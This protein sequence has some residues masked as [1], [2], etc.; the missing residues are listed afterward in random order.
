MK[1][2]YYK[3]NFLLGL[4][5]VSATSIFAQG[6]IEMTRNG[7]PTNNGSGVSTL[8]MTVPFSN[9]AANNSTFSANSPALTLTISFKN[10]QFTGLN[11]GTGALSNAQTTGLVFGAAPALASD[12][13]V[14]G[15]NAFPRYNIIGQYGGNG[16]PTNAM[17]TSSST[18]AATAASAS[19]SG[20]GIKVQ[21]SNATTNGAFEVFTTAQALFGSANG[22]GSRVYF[23]DIVLKFSRPVK[24]PVI[25]VAGLG[26][27]Y[28]FLPIGLTGLANYKRIFFST[29]L[30]LVNTGLTST[31]MSGNQFISLSGNNILNSNNVNPNGGSVLDP[32]ETPFDNLG[33]ATG[34]VRLNGTVQE[35]VY[36][37]YLESGTGSSAGFPW[38]AKGLDAG[39]LPL[40]TDALSDPFT[41]DIWYI[42]SSMDK[43]T[44]QVSGTVFYDE[45]GPA[46]NIWNDFSLLTPYA[47]TSV[48]GTLWANLLDNSGNV[49]ATTK[50]GSDGTYLF[51]NVAPGTYSVQTTTV[52]GVP[53]Q[54]A[55][56]S[57]LPTN[58]IT[59]GQQIG[60]VN[61][62]DGANDSKSVPFTVNSGDIQTEVNFGVLNTSPLPVSILSFNGSLVGSTAQLNWVVA[63]ELN[64]KGYDLERSLNGVDFVN[65]TNVA[66]RTNGAANQTYSHNDNI[67]NLGSNKFYYRLKVNDNDGSFRYTNVVLVKVA[68]IKIGKI[69]PNPFKESV[70]IEVE[71]KVK[72]T[73]TVRIVAMNGKVVLSQM[74]QLQKGGNQFTINGLN[75]LTS[76]TYII[77]VITS[78]DRLFS[79]LN[80]D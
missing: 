65:V 28:A 76:G 50:V 2:N 11:Y 57:L 14:Q 37:V 58:W 27:S 12:N 26:G 71:A 61:G 34:T 18:A 70:R 36:K 17:F 6:T 49:V 54:P 23:G 80:K 60:L 7:L 78:S 47:P 72:E 40:I 3:L 9:D 4:L 32:F 62:T 77:E 67:A 25:H 68:G 33:A 63:N 38:S 74:E 48:N 29:E 39:G 46:N 51:D 44:Q 24:N 73:A 21:G 31:L 19:P 43:P 64:L 35:V 20:T 1:K 10:Q 66:S 41:G 69:S 55:P 56:A 16:G 45:D 52:Q 22:I 15:A 13:V 59:T 79:K 75:N 30:E 53:G 8:P 42:A 5:L